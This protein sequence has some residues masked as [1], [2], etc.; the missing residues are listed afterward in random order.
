MRSPRAELARAALLAACLG[1]ALAG[2]RAQDDDDD[3]DG[4]T[5]AASAPAS[6][7]SVSA[8]PRAARVEAATAQLRADP[9][10]SGRH[11]EHTL[12][13][14]SDTSRERRKPADDSAFLA[15]M[16]A[17]ARFLNDTSRFLLWGIVAVL[18]A[19]ALV[20]ARRFIELRAFRRR[21]A[22]E[23]AVSHV[24]DLDVR[25]ASLPDDVGAAAWAL[26]QAGQVPA[27][28]S[29]LYRGALSRLIH[30]Y[31][32]PIR[33]AHTESECVRL[34]QDRLQLDRSAFFARL[35][36]V[37]QSAVYGGHAPEAAGVLSLCDQFDVVFGS[38]TPSKAPS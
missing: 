32:V 5:A 28:L 33:A 34:A 27:A 35:V 29:L 22:A 9:L 3:G 14:K 31:C 6:A 21:A 15:W 12:R 1:A 8:D 23:S 24:R 10:L 16:A 2:A 36:S 13:W 17:F 25:P 37:W 20:S 18:V 7:A 26:W 30:A 11:K 38:S 4:A 19:L